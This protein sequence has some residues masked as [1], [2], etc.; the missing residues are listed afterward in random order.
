MRRIKN[1]WRGT[2]AW[3]K[4]A[5]WANSVANRVNRVSVTGGEGYFDDQGLHLNIFGGLIWPGIVVLNGRTF[6][7]SDRES[8]VAEY[9]PTGAGT[10][11]DASTSKAWIEVNV[12]NETVR[13]VNAP[14]YDSEGRYPD[15]IEYYKTSLQRCSIHVTRL[16]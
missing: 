6:Y 8:L 5:D 10:I 16:G 7:D 14:A 1:N 11:T 9:G 15:G 13:Y 2:G 12:T 3:K 4:F